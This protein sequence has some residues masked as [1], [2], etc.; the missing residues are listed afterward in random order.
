MKVLQIVP[1]SFGHNEIPL[2][3]ARSGK[4]DVEIAT[5]DGGQGELRGA[6]EELGIRLQELA[7]RLFDLDAGALEG[8]DAGDVRHTGILA[9]ADGGS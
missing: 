1:S 6:A 7:G 8:N 3:I 9:R 5:L 2:S 4:G